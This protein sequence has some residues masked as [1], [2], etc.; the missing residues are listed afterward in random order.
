MTVRYNKT[1]GVISIVLG[2]LFGC[3]YFVVVL[4]GGQTTLFPMV[5]GV[6]GILF[7]ILFLIRPYF[8]LGEDSLTLYA[9]FGPAK[10]VYSFPSPGRLQ[11]KGQK[12]VVV[13]ADGTERP[14]P[15]TAWM[16]DPKDWQAFLSRL[17]TTE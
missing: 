1:V 14:V 15:L 11:R 13:Q 7:G 6:L 3:L 16:A 10:T 17:G 8:T 5:A 9:L 2:A 4:A 12:F